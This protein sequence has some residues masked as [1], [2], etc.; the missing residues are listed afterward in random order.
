MQP[1][2][3]DHSLRFEPYS[4]SNK[5]G[6]WSFKLDCNNPFSY[7]IFVL[8]GEQQKQIHRNSLW[9]SDIYIQISF[10]SSFL[11]LSFHCAVDE[12]KQE[13]W[14]QSVPYL[15]TYLFNIHE[16]SAGFGNAVGSS[17]LWAVPLWAVYRWLSSIKI[18]NL[19]ST[20]T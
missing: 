8:K 11:S 16:S 7:N 15:P 14:I 1:L 6:T 12:Q 4:V 19:L 9:F 17:Q 3:N 10:T 2:K 18:N 5:S 13:K 20:F